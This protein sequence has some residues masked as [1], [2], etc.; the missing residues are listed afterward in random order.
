MNNFY[1]KHIEG[2]GDKY[3]INKIGEIHSKWNNNIKEI[4]RKLVKSSDRYNMKLFK[5]L[6]TIDKYK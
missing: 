3:T 6:R 5:D 2:Y 4:K 1:T